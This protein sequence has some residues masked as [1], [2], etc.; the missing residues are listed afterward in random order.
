MKLRFLQVDAPTKKTPKIKMRK[1]KLIL[2]VI[3][4]FLIVVIIPVGSGVIKD[5]IHEG[6]IAENVEQ[7]QNEGSGNSENPG[8]SDAADYG[9]TEE[10]N[11]RLG[12]EFIHTL[13]S[14]EYA[15]RYKTTAMY[16][17]QPYEVETTYAVSGGS[18]ALVSAD[19]ATIVKDARPHSA[20]SVWRTRRTRARVRNPRS[21]MI[22]AP[23]PSLSP[24]H[25]E[26]RLKQPFEERLLLGH[27]AGGKRHS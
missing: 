19:L 4:L 14:G 12:S 22:F 27:D 1:R 7:A 16:E 8:K 26:Q 9:S 17:G 24:L 3:A 11:S 10:L 6:K 25:G 20:I 18:T 2:L 21:S 5:R 13:E 23:V 15:I